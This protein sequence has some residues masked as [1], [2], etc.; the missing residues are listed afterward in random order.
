[1]LA[2]LSVLSDTGISS[3]QFVFIHFPAT[4]DEKRLSLVFIM[5]HIGKGRRVGAAIHDIVNDCK[6]PSR[7]SLSPAVNT[8]QSIETM[9]LSNKQENCPMPQ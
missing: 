8:V 5:L 6:R 1:M 3:K 4:Q 2:A 7:G 9:H